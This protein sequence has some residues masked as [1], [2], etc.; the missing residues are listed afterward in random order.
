MR[1]RWR[2]AAG[3]VAVLAVIGAVWRLRD[4]DDADTRPPPSYPRDQL[5]VPGE[6]PRYDLVALARTDARR[7]RGAYADGRGPMVVTS[8]DGA[9]VAL[10][11]ASADAVHARDPQALA[12]SPRV[13]TVR[14]HPTLAYGG[15]LF[16][17][18]SMA[19]AQ[20]WEI[21]RAHV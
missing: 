20:T 7:L 13:P 8:I 4:G 9:V 11:T 17:G 5:L 19:T 14:G 2:W 18:T 12:A 6:I 10:T 3:M 15:H 1:R 21:G 16:P